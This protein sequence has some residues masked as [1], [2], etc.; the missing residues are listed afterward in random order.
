MGRFG[1]V[2]LVNGEPRWEA[3]A[4]R[5]EVVRLFLTNVSSTRVFNL[6]FR[7]AARE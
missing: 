6:S 2:L 7:G 1:N 4:R 3:R 5:G